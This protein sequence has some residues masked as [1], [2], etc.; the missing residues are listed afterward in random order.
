MLASSSVQVSEKYVL[1]PR[2]FE[3]CAEPTRAASLGAAAGAV[4]GR[5]RAGGRRDPAGCPS[6]FIDAPPS[7]WCRHEDGALLVWFAR[8][9]ARSRRRPVVQRRLG[10]RD[11]GGIG[12]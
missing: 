3:G 9:R 12:P 1:T 6:S 7:G 5:S 2:P 10:R 8:P 11:Q 4:G